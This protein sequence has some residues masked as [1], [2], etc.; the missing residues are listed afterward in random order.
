MIL[1]NSKIIELIQKGKYLLEIQNMKKD[2]I[3]INDLIFD[4]TS[5]NL[6]SWQTNLQ[7]GENLI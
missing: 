7:Y 5:L 3:P 4:T 1:S 2:K 6:H